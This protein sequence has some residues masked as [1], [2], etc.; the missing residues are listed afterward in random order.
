MSFPVPEVKRFLIRYINLINSYVNK[1]VEHAEKHHIVPKCLGGNNKNENI[2]KL[3][4]RAHFL[5]H[6]FLHKA[7]PKNYKL[8][9]AF[10]MMI[11]CNPYQSRRFTSRMY[12]LAKIQRSQAL[13]GIPRPA[14]VKEKLRKPKINKENYKHPKSKEHK[15]N[16]S[17]AL[18][19][20]QHKIGICKYCKKESSIPNISRWHN[21]KCKYVPLVSQEHSHR[22]F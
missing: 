20:K 4:P 15:K 3:P 18:K 9:L 6:Y 13:K 10:S 16:I 14:H 11:V 5:A 22:I 1:E 7:Y 17:N 8:S 2:I 21:E 19:G 12:E